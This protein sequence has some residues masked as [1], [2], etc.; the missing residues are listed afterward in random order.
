[1]INNQVLYDI[2][3]CN[4]SNQLEAINL[5]RQYRPYFEL[6]PSLRR[7][8]ESLITMPL[9]VVKVLNP[10]DGDRNLQLFCDVVLLMCDP[11]W[12]IK[13]GKEIFIF[14]HRPDEDFAGLLNRWRQVEVILGDE[15]YWML[16]WKH[17]QIMNDK[18][19]SHYPLFVTCSYTPERIKRGLAG[20]SL[21]FV[22]VDTPENPALEETAI[23]E[24]SPQSPSELE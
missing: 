5:L 20:G 1:M 12:K 15:Y 2:L 19:E 3:L 6:I 10:K 8:K 22:S 21:P 16:P 14:I 18:G 11:E 7:P 4:Y 9:P 17:Q 13:T 24:S 23:T